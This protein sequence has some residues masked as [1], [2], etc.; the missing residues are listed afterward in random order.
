M[1]KEILSYH[2]VETAEW[3]FFNKVSS[4]RTSDNVL[5]P[6]VPEGW[7]PEGEP[8]LES[9]PSNTNEWVVHWSIPERHSEKYIEEHEKLFFFKHP[10]AGREVLK[11][12]F[13]VVKETHS[14]HFLP[15]FHNYVEYFESNEKMFEF[16]E[17]IK[18]ADI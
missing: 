18:D 3:Y 13:V 15:F 1:K 14:D 9:N 12:A 4:I 17:K 7:G 6:E 10:R 16:I 8:Y 5:K 2:L 11:K